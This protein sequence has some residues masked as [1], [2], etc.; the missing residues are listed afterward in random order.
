MVVCLP[1]VQVAHFRVIRYGNESN[2]WVDVV[3]NTTVPPDI[4]PPTVDAVT[5]VNNATNI[6]IHTNLTAL[7][8]EEMLS[9][10]ISTATFELRDPDQN[11]IGASVSYANGSYTATLN[12]TS[13]LSRLT[14][15]TATIKGGD[16][17][18]VD[19]AYNH[20][21]SD[22]TWSFT[23]AAP[24]PIHP[25]VSAVS[26][27]NLVIGVNKYANVTARFSEEIDPSTINTS[28]FELRDSQN[29]IIP[30]TVSYISGSFTAI[31][32]PTSL[33][34][35]SALIQLES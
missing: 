27:Q 19:L 21:V 12:P 4:T 28:N 23:T 2:Y 10:S 29:N 22:F 33:L 9:G 35:N 30:A 11:L 25:T 16:F 7:F 1:M 6:D 15:Y 13:R 20:L 34:A 26:P 32:H 18:V 14:T 17:G 8:S 5:P 31:L 3:F 24:D